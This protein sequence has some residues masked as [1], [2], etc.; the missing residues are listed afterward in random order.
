M[1]AAEQQGRKCGL[2][3]ASTPT[4]NVHSAHAGIKEC[5]LYYSVVNG[6]ITASNCNRCS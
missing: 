2:S 4:Q 5:L 3:S 1:L 6:W